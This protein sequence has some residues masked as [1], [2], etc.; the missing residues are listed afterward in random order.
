MATNS[1]EV[2]TDLIGE[3]EKAMKW[4]HEMTKEWL[5]SGMLNG[6]S[7]GGAKGRK[8]IDRAF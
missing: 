2:P 7:R 6:E 4:S 8:D 5:E 1:C 3:C